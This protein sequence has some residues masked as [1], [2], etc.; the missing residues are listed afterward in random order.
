MWRVCVPPGAGDGGRTRTSCA[1]G[2]TWRWPGG[3]SARPARVAGGHRP[4][5]EGRELTRIATR[6]IPRSVDTPDMVMATKSIS[7]EEV[8]AFLGML[9]SHEV[10]PHTKASL[11]EA[12]RMPPSTLADMQRRGLLQPLR[13]FEIAGRTVGMYL[14]KEIE[15]ANQAERR[16]MMRVSGDALQK[17][18]RPETAA[19]GCALAEGIRG[20]LAATDDRTKTV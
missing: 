5:A 8:S 1:G 4:P 7:N 16:V 13:T 20:H 18:S 3:F 10:T 17:L 9:A 15:L 14:T 12:L 6:R 11:A 19:E 2:R